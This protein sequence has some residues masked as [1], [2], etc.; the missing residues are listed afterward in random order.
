[1]F[2]SPNMQ[3]SVVAALLAALLVAAPAFAAPSAAEKDAAVQASPRYIQ[4][5]VQDAEDNS[6]KQVYYEASNGDSTSEL[7]LHQGVTQDEQAGPEVATS[8]SA[9]A[10]ISLGG[11]SE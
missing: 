10:P 2:R 8:P 11:I 9:P 7:Q 4:T 6:L 1:M 3:S 5:S